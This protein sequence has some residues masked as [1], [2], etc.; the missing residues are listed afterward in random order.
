[1]N[2][3][4][5]ISEGGLAERSNASTPTP[6]PPA[7]VEIAD[8]NLWYGE[9]QALSKVDLRVERGLVTSLIGQGDRIVSPMISG[10]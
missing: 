2:V 9:F 1:M 5:T 7:A 3:H 8:L 6:T 10:S 4:A